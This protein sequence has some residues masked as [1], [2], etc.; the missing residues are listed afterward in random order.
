MVV[1]KEDFGKYK[2]IYKENLLGHILPFWEKHSI[3]KEDGGFYTCLG[4]DGSVYDTDKFVWLQCRQV[5]MFAKLYNEVEPKVGWLDIA[6][7]GADFLQRFGRSESGR[8]YFS[9]DKKGSPLVQPY[10]IFSDCFASM[11]FGQLGKI[12]GKTEHTAIA[13]QT[14]YNILDAQDNPKGKYEKTYPGTRKLQS[15][16]LPMILSNLVLE[17]SHILDAKVVDDQLN[18][19]KRKILSYFYKPE[20]GLIMENVG[21]DGSFSDTFQGRLVNPGHGLE[22]LW[23]LMDIAERQND[24]ELI[25]KCTDA[26]ISTLEYGWDSEYGGL[27][28]FMDLKGHPPEQLEWDHKLWWPH[29]EAMIA[30]AKGF[31][32][33]SDVRCWKWLM[34]LHEYT[35][36]HFVDEDHGEWFGYLSREGKVTHHLKGGKWKGCFHVPRGVLYL[37]EL[38]AK[39]EKNYVAQ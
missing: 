18:S 8:W 13:T 7:H 15:L 1:G 26:V 21:M 16:S 27:F 29:I 3:D 5:W 14:F 37:W 4:V 6:V 30:C 32:L 34:T 17:L 11:A 22:T 9:L 31:Y 33:T 36:S 25:Q 2:E 39:L 35:W 24:R 12:T 20:H 28:Y 23:F 19:V 38:M 10:N